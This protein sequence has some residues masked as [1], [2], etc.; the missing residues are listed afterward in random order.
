MI[1]KIA[2]VFRKEVNEFLSSLTAYITVSLFLL[3]MG[4]FLWVFPDT[5]I[6]Q[7]G[8]A[9]LESLFNIAP[10]VF[11]FLVP[12]IT[13][14]FIAEE[15]RMGTLELL[16]TSPVSTWQIILG[17]FFAGVL[18]VLFCL[19]PTL[20]Y[21]Y[22]VYQLGAVKG[23]LDSGA[24]A[25]SYTGLLLL[26]TAFTAIGLFASSLSSNQ[27]VAFML[28]VFLC[29][30]S[31]SGFESL[32]SLASLGN[33]DFLLVQIGMHEHYRSLSRGVVD[34][35]DLLYFASFTL[36]FLLA[37]KLKLESSNRRLKHTL[38]ALLIW[39]VALIAGNV[40]LFHYFTRF[41]LTR[42]QRYTL[43]E[44]TKELLASLEEPLVIKVFLE[45]DLSTDIRRLQIATRE[46]LNEYEAWSGGRLHIE[47]SDPLETGNGKEGNEVYQ[48]LVE[49]GLEPTSLN[50]RREEGTLQKIIFP[51]ALLHYRGK[52]LP[53]NFL[54]THFQTRSSAESIHIS[55]QNLEFKFTSAIH[56]L[57]SRER[58]RI[59]FITGHGEL[60][61]R[62]LIDITGTLNR[63]YEVKQVNLAERSIRELAAC[64]MLIIAKPREPFTEA[65]KYK[66]D[67][68]LMQGG[69]L[70]LLADRFNASLDSM[71]ARGNTLA[72]P[73][74]LNLD[75]LLF[76][77]GARIN[78]DLVRDLNCAPIPVIMQT[79]QQGDQ[80]LMP[81]VY[82]P[83]IVPR[84][85]HPVVRNID[86]VRMEFASS[87]DT[88][89]AEGI[90]KTVLLSTSP[91]T[92]RAGAPVYL[93]LESIQ[94]AGNPETFN[95]G[96]LPV[97]VLLEGS[98]TSVFRNRG[99]ENFDQ[100][101]P[102]R[103]KSAETRIVVVSDGDLIANEVSA[104]DNS[105]FPL[106]FDKYTRQTF[107]N[108]VF[109][110][111]CV[112]YLSGR[113]ELLS[114]RRKE[115]SMRMLD[116]QQAAAGAFRWK[117]INTALP[118]GIVLLFS[119]C[120]YLLRKRKYAR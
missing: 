8:Y 33:L 52:Q 61:G 48:K 11:I 69:R 104:I 31:W 98:F 55:V 50:V 56:T 44:T 95:A 66:L 18:L 9:S 114:L 87:I 101:S 119:L 24:I 107:G 117:L 53:V 97:G 2:A 62:Q 43:S 10:W 36:I 58:E 105:Y 40:I 76:A 57:I 96:P 54:G 115:I 83:L 63:S 15:K 75:D 16:A 41:D 116:R 6:L 37:A 19:L 102:F 78:Y 72:L 64:K 14:R 73:L 23:N 113:A 120:Y 118:I 100:S 88:I 84:S 86:P 94:D 89:A 1:W 3:T 38:R 67:Q 27:V 79:G 12:A 70:L 20:I 22:S 13:M 91:Y 103:E 29:F 32:S 85:R 92:Q 68:F 42:D 25:G 21:Y 108:K 110:E 7:Y 60:D 28:A 65:E 17:K 112:A 51:G 39:A 45:G 74:E 35:R 47:F 99:R 49:A 30:F 111:N 59:G 109:V 71:R 81:W 82:F 46:L 77:Y 106:G 93:S 4:L 26:G 90:S 34:T 5:S 80:Q